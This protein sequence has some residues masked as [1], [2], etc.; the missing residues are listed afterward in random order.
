MGVEYNSSLNE[1]TFTAGCSAIL[2]TL[3]AEDLEESCHNDFNGTD[4]FYLVELLSYGGSATRLQESEMGEYL[5]DL[6]KNYS[7]QTYSEVVI[8]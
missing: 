4:Q 2:S 6:D 8:P 3:V 5:E 1:E 7:P